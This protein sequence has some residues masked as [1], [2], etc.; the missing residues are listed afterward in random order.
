M[1]VFILTNLVCILFDPAIPAS[2][3]N[4]FNC[5]ILVGYYMYIGHEEG[6]ICFGRLIFAMCTWI[7][8]VYMYVQSTCT[9]I[10]YI[11]CA[12]AVYTS[13]TTREYIATTISSVSLSL[14]WEAN[15]TN[16]TLELLLYCK[17]LLQLSAILQT[18]HSQT[19]RGAPFQ[20]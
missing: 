3:F 4:S 20:V 15:D 2:S 17:P 8:T 12:C 7:V 11:M 13:T 1:D 18:S 9:I 16:N 6:I 14:L 10:C 5:F 19:G